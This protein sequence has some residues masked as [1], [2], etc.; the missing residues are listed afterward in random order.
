LANQAAETRLRAER[1][2]GAILIEL[3]ARAG[4]STMPAARRRTRPDLPEGT[5][6]SLPPRTLEKLGISPRDSSRFQLLSRI[7]DAEFEE[8]LEATRAAGRQIV[9]EAFLRAAGQYVRKTSG[10]KTTPAASLLGRALAL[11]RNVS[12]ITTQRELRLA[13][14]VV[15]IG[16]SWGSII[17]PPPPRTAT[18]VVRQTTCLLC[19]RGQPP[20]KPTLCPSCG[21][22]WLVS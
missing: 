8:R 15:A 10:R 11:L 17:D 6:L 20:S 16:A 13:R 18:A 12:S 3:T 1:R 22:R 14:E 2:C 9:V 4:P 19:G 7:P 5:R 21:G